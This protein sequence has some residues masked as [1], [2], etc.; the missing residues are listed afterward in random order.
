VVDVPIT[1]PRRYEDPKLTELEGEIV[2]RVMGV[3]GL[4]GVS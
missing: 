3:W 4:G 2:E 1:R